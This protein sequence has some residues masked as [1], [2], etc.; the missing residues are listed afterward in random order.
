MF[1]YYYVE[2]LWFSSYSGFSAD[3]RADG[4]VL[5][6]NICIRRFIFCSENYMSEILHKCYYPDSMCFCSNYFYCHVLAINIVSKV[7]SLAL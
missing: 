6:T 1:M 5:W 7:N 2:R 4:S 3:H